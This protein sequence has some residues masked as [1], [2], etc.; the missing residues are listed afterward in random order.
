MEPR[1]EVEREP[2]TAPEP[3]RKEEQPKLK[4]FRIVKLEERI[5]P[6]TS[7]PRYDDESTPTRYPCTR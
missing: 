2:Q 7:G 6:L 5:A 3:H 1:E 4:R